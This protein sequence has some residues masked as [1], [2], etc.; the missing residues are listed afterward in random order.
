MPSLFGYFSYNICK[1][2]AIG[3]NN[4]WKTI[5]VNLQF[6]IV[7]LFCITCYIERRCKDRL[8]SL[9]LYGSAD[10]LLKRAHVFTSSLI[11][12]VLPLSPFYLKALPQSD[13]SGPKRQQFKA[14]Y[15]SRAKGN[16]T[17]CINPALWGLMGSFIASPRLI[18][19]PP[20]TDHRTDKIVFS[21]SLQPWFSLPPL[22]F[23]A[24]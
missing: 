16:R 14:I 13:V 2:N 17:Y 11:L 6:Q 18:M 1:R 5:S 22:P 9:R 3:Q 20:S 15:S 12:P 21:A 4:L 8:L 24:S 10:T 19:V 23:L 7:A